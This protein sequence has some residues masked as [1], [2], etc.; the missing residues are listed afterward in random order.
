MKLQGT[1]LQTVGGWVGR[2]LRLDFN[3]FR[4]IE[5]QPSA[6]TA[7]VAVVLV[8]SLLAG[9]GSWL[10]AVQNDGPSGEVFLKS[11][12]LGA[13]I[14]TL[15]WLLWVY[16]AYQ[17]LTRHYR[18]RLEFAD[19]AR[20][21]GFAFAPVG[22]SVLMALTGMAIA[23]G[24]IAFAMAVLFTN[25]SIQYAGNL[26]VHEA[27]MANITGFAAFVLVMGIFANIAKVGALGGLAPGILFFSLNF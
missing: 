14:Q 6:T 8:A 12:A 25:I 13:V 20:L 9:I 17:V 26:D 2:L 24:L 1:D 18:L 7:A 21:M 27:T 16:L 11:L 10:W 4:E 5:A 15:V 22:L 23:F 19:L 3:V